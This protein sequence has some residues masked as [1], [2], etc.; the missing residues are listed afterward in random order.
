MTKQIRQNQEL[1][2]APQML[3]RYV[4]NL[5]E[6]LDERNGEILNPHDTDN[7]IKI[8]ER[9]VNAWFLHRATRFLTGNKNGFI[10]LMISIGYIEGIEQYRRGETSERTDT[11]PGRS[12]MFFGEGMVRI[13]N[14]LPALADELYG[15]LRCG[16]FHNGMASEKIIINSQ[17][18]NSIEKI[19]DT[20]IHINPNLFLRDI[21][22]DFNHY[23]R[24][25]KDS[26]NNQL[27]DNF[28]VMFNLI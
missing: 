8:Y 16:L 15:Q 26:N 28:N 17:Y 21:K 14:I 18:P 27:R 22:I 6:V 12:K 20:E 3:G 13:F 1:Y 4:N 10:V 25:L 11:Q 7:K 9:Q 19:D 5:A 2:V 23:I 24:E